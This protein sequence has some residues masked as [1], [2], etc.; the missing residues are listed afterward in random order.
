MEQGHTFKDADLA[1]LPA[2]RHQLTLLERR[3][4]TPG[5]TRDA[6]SGPCTVFRPTRERP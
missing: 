6:P 4:L 1:G 5:V 2:G 3:S